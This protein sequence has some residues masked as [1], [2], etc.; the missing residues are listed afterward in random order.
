MTLRFHKTSIYYKLF[1]A[2]ATLSKETF[3]QL[4]GKIQDFPLKQNYAEIKGLYLRG[5]HFFKKIL[6][7]DANNLELSEIEQIKS[8][9]PIVDQAPL[10]FIM[11]PNYFEVN[12]PTEEKSLDELMNSISVIEEFY[13]DLFDDITGQ[14]IEIHLRGEAGSMLSS[15]IYK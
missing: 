11:E 1:Y 8:I 15:K 9:S 5:E 2:H 6:L 3:T 7:S 10:P 4:C 12:L 14:K 13:K